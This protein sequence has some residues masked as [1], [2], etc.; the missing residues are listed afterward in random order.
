M[1]EA[2]DF[3]NLAARVAG[4]ASKQSNASDA[5]RLKDHSQVL[6]TVRRYRR[7]A[8]RRLPSLRGQSA[9]PAFLESWRGYRFDGAFARSS[10]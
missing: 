7:L 9:P 6:G 3:R 8:G 5:H 1:S 2:P 4:Q 10:V